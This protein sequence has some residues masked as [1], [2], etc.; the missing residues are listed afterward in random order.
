ME[1]GYQWAQHKDQPSIIYGWP[2]TKWEEWKRPNSLI[3]I[4]H[5]FPQDVCMKFNM[6][7]CK[8]IA[9][10]RGWLKHSYGLKLPYSEL[11][12]EIDTVEYKIAS[13]N[14]WAVGVI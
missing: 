3:N 11:I 6:D 8:V 1:C 4:E 14:V 13:I 12:K 10:Q 2:I 7:K 9:I 5:I